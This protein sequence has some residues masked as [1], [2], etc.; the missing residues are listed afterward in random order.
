MYDEVRKSMAQIY[1][2][3]P[4]F[5]GPLL[6]GKRHQ[7]KPRLIIY[8]IVKTLQCS[9]IDMAKNK[10]NKIA[11]KSLGRNE[12]FHPGMKCAI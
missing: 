10:H 4:S 9:V 5:F 2:E 12:R 1:V 8:M 6:R 3:K 7:R 11:V